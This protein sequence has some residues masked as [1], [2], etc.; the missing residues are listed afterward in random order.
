MQ[1][2]GTEH[3]LAN[4]EEMEITM[5]DFLRW[6][7]PNFLTSE[8]RNALSLFVVASSLGLSKDCPSDTMVWKPYDILTGDGYRLQVSSASYLQSMDE[9][10]PDFISF[11]VLKPWDADAFIFCLYK[12]S[13][14]SQNPLNL[15]LWDFFV[16]SSKSLM[17]DSD[18]RKS[19][20]LP[21]LQE[22]GVW[23][24]DYFGIADGIQKV[25]DV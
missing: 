19:I 25:M 13:A 5:N 3:F 2:A 9:E 24:C 20:T 17:Q 8:R 22:L 21:R 6:S 23:Q 10:H 4:G 18:N 7:Y 14:A 15:D 11:E 12:G 1:Y 16:I